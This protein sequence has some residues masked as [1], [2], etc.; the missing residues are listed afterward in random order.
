M[1]DHPYEQIL[2]RDSKNLGAFLGMH[3]S[4]YVN[5]KDL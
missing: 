4:P 3:L 2:E 1:G 5:D